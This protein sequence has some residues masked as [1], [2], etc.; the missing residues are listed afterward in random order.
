M[1]AMFM[2]TAQPTQELVQH[3]YELW[4]LGKHAI[5]NSLVCNY[6]FCYEVDELNFRKMTKPIIF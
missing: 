6:I 4:I 1:K 5:K 3:S 2:Q